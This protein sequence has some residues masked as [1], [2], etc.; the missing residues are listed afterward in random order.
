[1]TSTPSMGY[2]RGPQHRPRGWVGHLAGVATADAAMTALKISL[3]RSAR[4]RAERIRDVMADRWREKQHPTRARMRALVAHPGARFVWRDVPAPP[5]PEPGAAVVH[6]IAVATCD[7]DRAMALGRSPFPLPM[8]FGH[9]CVGEVVE[10]GDEVTTVRPGDR[11]VVPFQISCGSCAACVAGLTAN[12]L[13][14]P[15]I[16]MYGFGLVGGLWGGAFSD[17]LTVPFAEAMLVPLPQ[18]IEPAAAASVADNVADGYRSI[19]PYLPQ[20]LDRGRDLDVVI[21]AEIGPRPPFSAS[22]PLYAGLTAM[23]LG[24]PRVHLVD[25]RP[26]VRAHAEALGMIAHA[27]VR[28]VPSAPLVVDSTGDRRGPSLA[29]ARTSPDG[30]VASLSSLSRRSPIPTALMYGRNIRYELGRSHARAHIPA[31]LEMMRTGAL[32]PETVTTHLASLDTADRTLREHALGESTKT[33]L[34]E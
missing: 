30:I 8:A 21:F 27:S 12:C 24:A 26:H 20:L 17:L 22:V 25:R 9:E 5:S 28:T 29:I 16:S 10:V 2:P 11:V 18:G 31:I 19:A 1:M 33:I 4:Q 3:E 6:P 34:V 7:L 23:A 13:T 14:V 15:P 32:R